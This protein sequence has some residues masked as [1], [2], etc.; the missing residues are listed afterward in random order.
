MTTHSTSSTPDLIIFDCD[1]VLVDSE[2]MS[3]ELLVEFI[4]KAGV[5]IDTQDAYRAFLGKPIS[6]VAQSMLETFGTVIPPI[7]EAEF[8]KCILEQF[9][10]RL[11]PIPGIAK[12]LTQ[13]QG[14]KCVASSSSLERVELS[15]K[16]TGLSALLPGH[17]FGAG[18]V[19]NGKPSPDLFLHAAVQHA[20]PPERCI[21]IED[22]P[23][24]LQAAKAAGMHSIAF[25]GGA[26]ATPAGLRQKLMLHNPDILIESMDQLPAAILKLQ[27]SWA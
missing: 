5:T 11:K 20:T 8:Q 27:D 7:D 23:A 25:V 24:G 17:K 21:V 16:V 6:T 22:S 3:V 10:D 1:G 13:L 15:L 18:T 9:R 14:P 26:H 12:A 4:G 2:P 19:Q